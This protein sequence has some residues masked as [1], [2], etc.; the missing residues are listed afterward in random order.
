MIYDSPGTCYGA[1]Y[2]FTINEASVLLKR[3][4]NLLMRARQEA[5]VYDQ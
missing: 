2:Y 3:V 1:I 5:C 4:H